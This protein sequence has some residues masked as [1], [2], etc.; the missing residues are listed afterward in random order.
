MPAMPEE[1]RRFR[2]TQEMRLRKKAEF[3][4]VFQHRNRISDNH[5]TLYMA[6]NNL[7]L[8]RLGLAVGRKYGNAVARNRFKRLVREAF[9][10]L[11]PELPPGSDWIAL[12]QDGCRGA[13]ADEV[14]E[15]FARL[16]GVL[17]RRSARTR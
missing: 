13:R 3:D 12:P 2:F 7:E 6:P 16:A 14:R 4:R 8:V 10:H 9:R 5:L 11:R 17:S 1:P 15:S